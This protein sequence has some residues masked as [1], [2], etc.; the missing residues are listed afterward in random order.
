MSILNKI[1]KE[2]QKEV[3]HFKQETFSR[4]EEKPII[5]FK[6]RALSSNVMTIIAEIKRASP[7]KGN[8][9]LDVDPVEQA[10]AYE[11]LGASAISV[12]TDSTFFKGS[13]ADLHAVSEA[14]N[15]P[16]LCKDFMIDPVQIDQA[17][18]AGAHMILLIVAALDDRQ[19]K[20][21]FQYATRLGLEVLCE[22]HTVEEMKRALHLGATIIGINNRDL[23]TFTVDLDTTKQLSA[24][25][26]DPNIVLVSESGIQTKADV[27]NVADA[28]AH[29]ILVGETLMRSINLPIT[30]ERLQLPLPKKER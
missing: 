17:K 14:V 22:V 12:L 21:L 25:M 13:F 7:S 26:T 8:I 20:E 18:A 3:T 27:A 10:K 4:R 23:K 2:K 11:K 19:L 6:Q 29:A 9:H 24:L 30:F 15:L 5:P 16:V 1:L 28:G